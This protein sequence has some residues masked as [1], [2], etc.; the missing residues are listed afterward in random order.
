MKKILFVFI[1]LAMFVAVASVKADMY[2]I[3]IVD[4]KNGNV[5]FYQI[6][7]NIFGLTG[8]AAYRASNDIFN[9]FGVDPTSSWYTLGETEVL[10][11]VRN[12]S[13]FTA[14][15]WAEVPGKE[16][17]LLLDLPKVVAQDTWLSTVA[18]TDF[19]QNS[20]IDFRLDV[21]RTNT[22]SPNVSWSL[23]SGYNDDGRVYMLGLDITDFYNAHLG[24]EGSDRI[25]SVIMFL[26]ED[27]LLGQK[28]VGWGNIET[29][30][31]YADVIYIM[32]NVSTEE[33]NKIYSTPEP[34]TLLVL[35]FGAIGAGF[36][37]R[38]RMKG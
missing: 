34:A 38:R 19:A 37:A 21:L 25:D 27:W 9:E 18:E 31:D 4:D 33:P 13:G 14:K 23:T 1:A 12:E 24:L 16:D 11:V 2:G 35:G 7:N 30:W 29:D 5:N 26:W 10:K 6:F 36:A 8:T 28:V 20:P 15:L 32:T 22:N 17:S 3:N